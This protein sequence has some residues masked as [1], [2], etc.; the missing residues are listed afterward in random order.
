MKQIEINGIHYDAVIIDGAI[1]LQS[2]TQD[3]VFDNGYELLKD[4][5]SSLW[6]KSGRG[7]GPSDFIN[8][9]VNENIEQWVMNNLELGR[10]ET[11]NL[12]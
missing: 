3:I 8:D 12:N 7:F 10:V 6:S 1:V 5:A 11:Y 2:I 9:Y 4:E